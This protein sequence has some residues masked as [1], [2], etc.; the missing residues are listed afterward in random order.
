[1]AH[2]SRPIDRA[3]KSWFDQPERKPL[4][5]RGAR[6]TGKTAAVR[7][8]A[9]DADLY[10]E[11]NLERFDDQRLVEACERPSDLVQ[12]LR[13]RA[14][15]ARFPARTLIFLDEIQVSP[16][17]VSFLRF[18]REDHPELAVVAAG[19]LLEGR[20]KEGD[21][22]F[23]VGRVTF[24][25]L[26]P[27]SFFEFLGAV[28]RGALA[29]RLEE[30]TRGRGISSALH[31]ESL[32]LLRDYLWVGGMPEAVNCWA[33][34]RSA[35]GVRQIQA[36]LRQAFAEDLQKYTGAR[37]SLDTTFAHLPHHYGQRFSYE[38]FSPGGSS[39]ATK[40]ALALLD[41]AMIV[42]LCW[43][44]SDVSP[45]LQSRAKAAPKLLPLD[46]G[47]MLAEVGVPFPVVRSAPLEGVLDGRAAEVFVGLQILTRRMRTNVPLHFWV[48][49][50][51]GNAELD[52]LAVGP[53]GL[54][55]VEVKAGKQ[56]TLRSLHQFLRRSGMT[57]GTRLYSGPMAEE[58]CAVVLD[59]DPL[60]YRLRSWPLYL[61]EMLEG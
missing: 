48:S 15:V 6:Q 55:P 47:L 57:T 5:L 60:R 7:H 46:I 41:N 29:A 45:P 24:R 37:A 40:R 14:N 1:M 56:G 20:L 42:R 23:P 10:I 22:A 4:V 30:A 59:G 13:L 28:D 52:W 2:W 9:K 27:F 35:S 8:L 3:L 31:E 54:L 43:P 21:F 36:D 38:K 25:Y 12:A 32:S 61:A 11:L 34:D 44:T 18:F 17:A 58:D 16:K 51:A 53:E 39:A 50:G 19:S 49:E 26:R 33:E